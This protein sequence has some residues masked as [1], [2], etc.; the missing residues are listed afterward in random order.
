MDRLFNYRGLRRRLPVTVALLGVLA[1]GLI[2]AASSALAQDVT[3]MSADNP[4]VYALTKA[5]TSGNQELLRFRVSDPSQIK[6]II[7]ITGLTS[8][9]A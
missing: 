2:V 3:T 9:R 8:G 1:G 4:N 7:P 5:D 6:H